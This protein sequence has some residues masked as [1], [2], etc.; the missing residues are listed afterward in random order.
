MG[1]CKNGRMKYLWLMVILIIF[2]QMLSAIGFPKDFRDGKALV[3]LPKIAFSD[4]PNVEIAVHNVGEVWLTVT[5]I[6]QFGLGYLGDQVDPL[7]GLKAPSCEYPG[8]SNIN[9]LYV[10]G[11]WIG[12]IV[13]RDTLVSIG[14]DDYY[15]V[16]EFWPD[17]RSVIERRSIQPSNPFFSNEAKSEQDIIADYSDILTNPQYVLTDPTDGRP[18]IPLNIEVE[19]ESYAWSYEYAQD[20]ILF[21][22][23]IKNIGNKDLHKVYMA[24]YVDGDVHHSSKVG[25]E[26]YGDDLC[27][28]LRTFPSPGSACEFLDT[29]NIAYITDNDGDPDE[30]GKFTNKS[31][32]GVAGVRV[33]RTP[34]DSL[35]YSF[36]WWATNYNPSQDFG[37]RRTGTIDDPFRNMNGILGTP[38]GD[39]NKY[40]VMRHNEFDYDQLFAG[41]DH[42]A[43]GWLP[44]P[45]NAADIADGFDARYLLSFGPFDISPGEVL[46]VS[47]AWVLG[48]K[49]HRNPDDYEKYFNI[50]EPERYYDTWDF[51]DLAKNSIWASWVY[52]NPGFDSDGDGYM[53]DFRVCAFESTLVCDSISPDSMVCDWAYTKADT[54]Y[55]RGD[56]IPDFRGAQPPTPP[57]LRIYPRMTKQDG[58]ELLVRWNGL[59]SE[60]EK[61]IFSNM[62]DFE[63]YRTL[64]S[65]TDNRSDFTVLASFDK[66]DYDRWVWSYQKEKWVLPDPPLTLDSLRKIYGV[67][68]D[69]MNYDS[70]HPFP[71]HNEGDPDSVF[72]FSEQ[73]WNAGDLSDTLGIHKRFPDE[74]FPSTLNLDSAEIYYPEEL[75][76]D[77]YLKYFEYEYVLRDLLPSRLYYVSVTAFDYGSPGHGLKALET[78]PTI[79]AVGAYPQNAVALVEEKRPEVMVYPNPY[80]IDGQYR[81]YGFEGLGSDRPDDRVRAIHFTNLPHKCTIKIYS[82]DGDLIREINHDCASEDPTCM[83]E[84]WDLITRNTQAVVSGIYYYVV[85]SEFGNQIGK[86][87]IIM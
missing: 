59:S 36:N 80:R 73:D 23:S 45:D 40:Y 3:K 41:K 16:V 62:R 20:F 56:G 38:N 47:F 43:A 86:L 67:D 51:S 57:E 74:P 11:F 22:Y 61:D 32:T 49:L 71:R 13:G 28:F 18:H 5:N 87:V 82:I 50:N 34:S 83:H 30:T 42:S 52:D 35:N 1:V 4:Q 79:N 69:P 75:T 54:T 37:P 29:I 26:G 31:A 65:L 6:G 66:K 12:A 9:Y 2:P 46:P 17:S 63:G 14:V 25:T 55:Y 60:M 19:Q 72:Y 48:E 84:Q 39:A 44:R 58:G 7:T 15:S 27:G 53:G 76:E 21:N 77:G 24:I 68:F 64:V 70:D 8:G 78:N 81:A 33:V 10:G 85:E